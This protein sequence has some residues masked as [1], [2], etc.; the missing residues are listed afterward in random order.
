[1]LSKG[2]DLGRRGVAGGVVGLIV[3][4]R[5]PREAIHNRRQFCW[6]SFMHFLECAIRRHSLQWR[7]LAGKSWKVFSVSRRKMCLNNY[8]ICVSGTNVLLPSS[9]D[10]R[11]SVSNGR[12]IMD[13]ILMALHSP[14]VHICHHLQYVISLRE[15]RA[16]IPC[17]VE[18]CQ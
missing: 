4:D 13:E 9:E 10:A 17:Y 14:H 1:M 18:R 2:C 3:G 6:A 16:G 11:M 5:T 7:W 12:L 8:T 15:Y